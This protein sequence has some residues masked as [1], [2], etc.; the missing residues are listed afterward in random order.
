M[1]RSDMFG[2]ILTP[3]LFAMLRL[4]RFSL[5]NFFLLVLT[6]AVPLCAHLSLCVCSTAW[7]STKRWWGVVAQPDS[8]LHAFTTCF[9][10]RAPLQ[11]GGPVPSHYE[12][13]T[14]SILTSKTTQG[15]EG[16]KPQLYGII[17][18]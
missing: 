13:D 17:R 4:P 9:T 6:R 2:G 3:A 7:W 16:V 8:R 18:V 1:V 5:S 14:A 15:Y 10:A 11:P 12:L